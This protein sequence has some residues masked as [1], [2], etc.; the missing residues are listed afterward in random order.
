MNPKPK[1][2]KKKARSADPTWLR[3]AALA[4]SQARL[5]K[6]LGIS[7]SQIARYL[8][9][10][11]VPPPMVA[12]ELEKALRIPKSQVRPDLFPE[13]G[14]GLLI[15]SGPEDD[16]ALGPIFRGLEILRKRRLGPLGMEDAWAALL[17]NE[18]ERLTKENARLRGE[19]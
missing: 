15:D 3:A 1:V 10:R 2:R 7:Q 8:S 19:A 11:N 16:A 12:Y 6:M 5:A 14:G 17:I 18:I 9:G 4:G 13:D